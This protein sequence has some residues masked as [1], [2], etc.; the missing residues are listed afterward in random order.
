MAKCYR[1]DADATTVDHVPPRCLTECC[2]SWLRLGLFFIV[3]GSTMTVVVQ[4]VK[5][6]VRPEVTDLFTDF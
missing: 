5:Q 6:F 1:C 3:Y 2:L 4:F